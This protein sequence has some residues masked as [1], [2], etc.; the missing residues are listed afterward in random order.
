MINTYYSASLRPKHPDG[1]RVQGAHHRG[2]TVCG[3]PTATTELEVVPKAAA[4]VTAW[5][6]ALR[7]LG[8][9]DAAAMAGET[10]ARFPHLAVEED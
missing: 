4:A 5:I 9:K 2:P 3:R 6:L 1:R 7:P 8:E 10:H